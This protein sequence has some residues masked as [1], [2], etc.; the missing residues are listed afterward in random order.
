MSKKHRLSELA[1]S[2]KELKAWQ[3]QAELRL[4]GL[5]KGTRAIRGCYRQGV[6]SIRA[7]SS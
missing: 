2:I 3:K 4:R 6:L 7:S 5:E 1:D